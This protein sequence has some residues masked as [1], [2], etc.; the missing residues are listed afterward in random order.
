MNKISIPTIIIGA[1]IVLLLVV[2]LVTYQVRFNEVAVKVSNWGKKGAEVVDAPGLKFRWPPPIETIKKFDNRLNVLDTAESEVKTKDQQQIIVGCYAIWR[3]KDAHEFYIQLLG[4]VGEARKQLR[5]RIGQKRDIVIGRH[6]FSEFINHDPAKVNA[7]YDRIDA[8]ILDAAAPEV[9]KAYG[10]ELVRVGI[11]RISLHQEATAGVLKAME[12][13]R[14]KEAA[15][16]TSE[17]KGLAEA[18][19]AR[20]E[21][22]KRQ[23]LAFAGRKAEQIAV[24][25]VQASTRIFEQVPQEDQKFFIWLQKIEA[26]KASLKQKSTIFLDSTSE[27]F[28]PFVQPPDDLIPQAAA[29]ENE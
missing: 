5:D 22:A 11:R 6:E 9:L 2:K 16:I 15:K 26:L 10:I 21:S 20:A 12:Q 23:I 27:L 7:S 3:I 14:L 4:N 29:Q 18:I 25:G 28:Q 24:A 19:K 1:L 17:G 13:D 8:E